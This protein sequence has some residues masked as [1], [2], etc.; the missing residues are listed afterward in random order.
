MPADT[1][2]GRHKCRQTQVPARHKCRQTQV[3]AG[4]NAGRYKCRPLQMPAVTNAGQSGF[5]MLAS[6]KCR[7]VTNAGRYKCRQKL[8]FSVSSMT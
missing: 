3:P 1:N 6:H 7:P 4:T 5:Q 2:T 8:D